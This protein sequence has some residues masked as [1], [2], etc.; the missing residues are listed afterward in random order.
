[1]EWAEKGEQKEDRPLKVEPRKE[2]G[3]RAARIR[4]RVASKTKR[5]IYKPGC[6]DAKRKK[7]CGWTG[8]LQR[9]EDGILSVICVTMRLI[10]M[11]DEGGLKGN[12]HRGDHLTGS[13]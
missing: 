3:C 5:D 12:F 6:V 9:P 13:H 1:M 11:K 2:L 8:K 4:F 7:L 10:M